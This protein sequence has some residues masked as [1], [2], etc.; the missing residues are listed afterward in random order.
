ML[1]VTSCDIVKV[2]TETKPLEVSVKSPVVESGAGQT[3]VAVTC[4]SDWKL[5]MD[6]ATAEPWAELNVT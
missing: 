3:F 6:F 2:T 1:F 4:S 5:A